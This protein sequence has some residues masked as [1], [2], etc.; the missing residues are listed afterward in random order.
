M[1]ITWTFTITP[2]DIPNKIVKI[3][4]VRTDDAAPDS[5]FTVKSE[6]A[7]IS[8][9]PLKVAALNALWAKYQDE[10]AKKAALDAIADIISDL[11][12]AAKE[13]FEARE[14]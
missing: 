14:S 2:I 13:D 8:S 9:G 1:A 5:I 10:L 11:E 7:D 6:N 4:A 3:I 12:T